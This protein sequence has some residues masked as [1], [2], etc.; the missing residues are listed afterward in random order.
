[1][2]CIANCDSSTKSKPTLFIRTNGE[3]EIESL[4]WNKP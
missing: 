3:N 1:M 2:I 4:H